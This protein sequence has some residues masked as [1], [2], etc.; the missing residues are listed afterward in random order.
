ML[1]RDMLEVEM[2]SNQETKKQKLG[3][4]TDQAFSDTLLAL[5]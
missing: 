2:G 1:K 5:L 3:K 4:S